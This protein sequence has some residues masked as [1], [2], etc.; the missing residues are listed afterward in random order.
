MLR[1][2]KSDIP[3]KGWEYVGMEDLGEDALPGEDIPY[4][5]CEMCGKEKIRYV[6]LLRHPN[7]DGEIRVG[8][9]CAGKMIND[10]VNPKDRESNLRNR[11][12]RRKNFLNREWY[13][14]PD[15]GNYT[16]R[17]KG[18]Q[19][20]IARNKLG[21]GWG[22]VFRGKW[23]WEYHGKRITDFD[24]ARIV[25]FN[26]FDEL[27]ESRHQDQPYWDDYRWVYR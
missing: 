19:I 8:C 23:Q 24:T 6:H 4:E 11:V 25:A 10:Y 18:E 12:R 20:T 5:Q 15:T 22:V 13:R 16:M 17:Y 3:Q 1:Q 7:Y 9:D 27:H 2:N 14:K 26:L 21:T